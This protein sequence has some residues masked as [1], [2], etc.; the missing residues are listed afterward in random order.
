VRIGVR[1]RYPV[2]TLTPTGVLELDRPDLTLGDFFAVWRMPS[3][4][5]ACSRSAVR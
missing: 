5:T 2:R 3:R 1:C 4:N